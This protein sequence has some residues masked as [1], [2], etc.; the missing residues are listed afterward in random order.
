M[1]ETQGGTYSNVEMGPDTAYDDDLSAGSYGW[2]LFA[3]FMLIMA[4]LFNIIDGLVAITNANYYA[5]NSATHNIQLPITNNLHAWGWT[6]LI[7]GC[8][9]VFAGLVVLTGALWARII[10]VVVVGL[11]M[12]FR[13]AFLAAFPFWG[14]VI[15]FIDGLVIYALIVHGGREQS[16]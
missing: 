4:G 9:I 11:N 3:S 7:I 14:L 8:V 10:G 13:L 12:L 15:L 6:A 2:R 16:V 5:S 1:A